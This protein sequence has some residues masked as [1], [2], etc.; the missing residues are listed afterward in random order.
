VD[1]IKFYASMKNF[2]HGQKVYVIWHESLYPAEYKGYDNFDRDPSHL[3]EIHA[4]GGEQ[5]LEDELVFGDYRRA[6]KEF[7]NA[8]DHVRG[9]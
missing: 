8:T 9:M 2:Q 4:A 6:A 3:V 5:N 7:P 1:L